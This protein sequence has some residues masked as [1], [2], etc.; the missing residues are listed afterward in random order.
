MREEPQPNY[1]I[2]GR[3]LVDGKVVDDEVVGEGGG[4]GGE[5]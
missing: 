3:S 5:G 1:A 4:E 2:N